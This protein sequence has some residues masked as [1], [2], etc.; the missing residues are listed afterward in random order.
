MGLKTVVKVGGIT[1]LSDARYCAGMGVGLLGFNIDPGNHDYVTPET[2][3]EITGWISGIDLV[4]ETNAV[5]LAALDNYTFSYIQVNSRSQLFEVNKNGSNAIFAVD[6]N[7]YSLEDLVSLGNNTSDVV[8][9]YLFEKMP[10]KLP[11]AMEMIESFANQYPV[12]LGFNINTDNLDN[13]LNTT[14]KGI[15]MHGSSEDKPGMKTYDELADI[16]ED[17]EEE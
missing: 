5:H 8:A 11:E 7:D 9:Y 15:A 4:V 16:L 1:N 2:F 10:E 13:I 12:L 6:I 3:N 14:I 17:L